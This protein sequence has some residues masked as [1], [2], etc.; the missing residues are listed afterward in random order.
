MVGSRQTVAGVASWAAGTVDVSSAVKLAVAIILA[1]AASLR[2]C[3]SL[4]CG[5]SCNFDLTTVA[6]EGSWAA[7][8]EQAA[9]VCDASLEW[10]CLQK[11][12]S[13][14]RSTH[15]QHT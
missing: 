14:K 6:P 10:S 7:C 4:L 5:A 8:C 1:R 9:H 11:H 15:T 13:S 3:T 2:G 12:I